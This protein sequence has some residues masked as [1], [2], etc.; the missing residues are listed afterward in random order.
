MQ[1]IVV[2]LV[3]LLMTMSWSS[4]LKDDCT[5]HRTFIRLDPI[6]KSLDA[7]RSEFSIGV[8]RDLKN[9]GKIYVYGNY[10]LI[11]EINEGI[12]I[13]DNSNPAH[14]VP[15]SFVVISGNKD[16][17]VKENVMYADNAIDLL[18]IDISDPES[19]KFLKRVDGVFQKYY[20]WVGNQGNQSIFLGYTKSTETQV[21]DC[22]DPNFNRNTFQRGGGLWFSTDAFQNGGSSAAK[23]ATGIAGSL[24]RFG[25]VGDYLY[26]IDQ[27]ELHVFYVD[28][29]KDPKKGKSVQVSWNIETLFPYKDKLFIGAQNGMYIMDNK[30]PEAP[31]LLSSFTHARA[32]DPV[33]VDG[34]IAYITL[35][36]GS[37]CTNFINELDVVD[38]STITSPRLIKKYPMQNPHGLSILDKTLYLCEGKFGFKVYGVEDNKTIDKNLKAHLTAFHAYDVIAISKAQ[39]IVVGENGL[40]QLDATDPKN[41]KSVSI[42][43]VVKN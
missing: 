22:S 43:P 8:A 15:L 1:K 5:S 16:M 20:G 30:N 32:C 28:Q 4:C 34:D 13:I 33:F 21:L 26:A 23:A 31:V 12:H 9:P 24:S 3:V 36:D 29:P 37:E 25:V 17:A 39:L 38:I 6:Y 27:S 2:S 11:N 19:P 7:I 40:M 14:P 18:A 41:I 35:K 10:L 42:I